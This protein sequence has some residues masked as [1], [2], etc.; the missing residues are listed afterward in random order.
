MK[1]CKVIAV[2]NQKGGVGKTTTSINLGV[3]LA[4]EGNRVLLIDTD[5]QGDLT[6]CLGATD[7][8]MLPTTLSTIMHKVIQDEPIISHE[9]IICNTE[10]VDFLPSN[11][12]LAEMEVALVNVMSRET[13]LKTYLDSLKADYD[14]I[15]IISWYADYQCTCGLRQ[16]FNPCSGT[17][18]IC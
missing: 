8:D 12:E 18:A 15:I 3:G 5:P 14:Y 17:T 1:D 11:I 2:C 13:V 4:R 7:C 6:T 9:G 16:C 10:N